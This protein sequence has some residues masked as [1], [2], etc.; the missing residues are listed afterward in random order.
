MT[1]LAGLHLPL[2]VPGMLVHSSLR[3]DPL[4][5][6]LELRPRLIVHL[7]TEGTVGG[8]ISTYL[9]NSSLVLTVR[10]TEEARFAW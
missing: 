7:R 6:M 9:S 10:T 3:A 1:V 4:I 5:A 8:N 2:L